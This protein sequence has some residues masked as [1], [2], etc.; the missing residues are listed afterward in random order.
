[1]N[2]PEPEMD[3]MLADIRYKTV[4]DKKEVMVRRARTDQMAFIHCLNFYK[5]DI[6][7]YTGDQDQD[8]G[9]EED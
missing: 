4:L 2:Q 1:M 7:N 6:F 5:M 3:E 9:S 8:C